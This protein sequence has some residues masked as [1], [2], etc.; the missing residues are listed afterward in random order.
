MLFVMKI[1]NSNAIS[2]R[3]LAKTTLEKYSKR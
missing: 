1:N 2:I 3:E